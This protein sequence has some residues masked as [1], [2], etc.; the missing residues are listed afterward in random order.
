M[1]RRACLP[2]PPRTLMWRPGCAPHVAGPPAPQSIH[3]SPTMG[4]HVA[5]THRSPPSSSV[6]ASLPK[7]ERSKNGANHQTGHSVWLATTVGS[8]NTGTAA[9]SACPV[10]AA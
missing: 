1:P 3:A 9:A 6:A 2:L 7:L 4:V 5:T 8:G 10:V